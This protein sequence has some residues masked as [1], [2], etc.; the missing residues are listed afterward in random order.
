[1]LFSPQSLSLAALGLFLLFV[2]PFIF[3]KLQSKTNKQQE[4]QKISLFSNYNQ[5]RN[6]VENF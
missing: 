6:Q 3:W 2:F 4:Q 1:M 5:T